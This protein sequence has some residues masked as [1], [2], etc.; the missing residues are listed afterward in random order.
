METRH[1]QAMLD[2]T[3]ISSTDEITDVERFMGSIE[4]MGQSIFGLA[5][6]P[7]QPTA[8]KRRIRPIARTAII[9]PMTA[10]QLSHEAGH[11]AV[12]HIEEIESVMKWIR[13]HDSF[14]QD[15]VQPRLTD[16]NTRRNNTYV[17]NATNV[18]NNQQKVLFVRVDDPTGKH[19]T[20]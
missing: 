18:Q 10:E 2:V 12:D 1:I 4:A 16:T 17:Y 5:A 20:K 15:V 7:N 9:C 19:R 3:A 8:Y 6:Q 14:V 13:V 11:L